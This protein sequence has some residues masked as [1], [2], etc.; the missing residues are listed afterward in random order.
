MISSGFLSGRGLKLVHT[1]HA[2]ASDVNAVKDISRQLGTGPF[3]LVF[4]FFSPETDRE[5][6]S[7]QLQRELPLT[8]VVGCSTAGEISDTGYVEGQIVAVGFPDHHFG[9]ETVIVPDLDDYS[10][11][12]LM[13]KLM[14]ARQNLARRHRHFEHEFACLLVDGLSARED[15][16]T[17]ALSSGIGPI[18]VF[19]GSAGDGA[20][21]EKTFILDGYET[22]Q[23]AA[24][25]TF[26]R[27]NC[28]IQVF[29]YDHLEPTRQRMVVTK[30]EPQNRIVTEINAEPAAGEYARLIG[31]PVDMLGPP[32][33]AANPV[34]VRV[35][36]R[37]H[38]RAIKHAAAEGPIDF[39]A[40]IDEG[41]VLTLA[42]PKDMTTHLENALKGLE[43]SSKPAMILACDCIFRRIEAEHKQ[44]KQGISALLSANNV[45]GFST[46]G[47]QIGAIHVNQTITG[48]AIYP[49]GTECLSPDGEDAA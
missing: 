42:K 12:D 33:F 36:E 38:V 26:F 13:S 22:R 14:R 28:P 4:V 49:P 3:A 35:G 6:L 37:H 11:Q 16:L 30:A 10:P 18:P 17:S 9:V 45:H 19:G 23:N 47:E 7:L 39:F 41:M 15:E 44:V 48:V 43:R 31:V 21:F 40:A 2:D 1:A 20:R 8:R 34:V 27:T 25:L 29:S 5:Q 32:V 24:V 46:Y